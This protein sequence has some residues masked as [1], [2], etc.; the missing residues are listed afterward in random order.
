MAEWWQWSHS[1]QCGRTE[2]RK[3]CGKQPEEDTILQDRPSGAETPNPA[4]KGDEAKPLR[5]RD[6]VV[7]SPGYPKI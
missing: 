5:D 3:V 7:G 2:H 6:R 1:L 4:C